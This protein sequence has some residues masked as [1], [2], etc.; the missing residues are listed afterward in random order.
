MSVGRVEG[1]RAEEQV[2]RIHQGG[3][4][5]FDLGLVA[6]CAGGAFEGDFPARE[7]GAE[8]GE[9]GEGGR[10]EEDEIGC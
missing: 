2:A 5:R 7:E 3:I 10:G 9:G 8:T 1:A 4:E 6:R